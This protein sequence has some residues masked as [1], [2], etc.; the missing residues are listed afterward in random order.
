[1]KL[2]NL[3][4]IHLIGDYTIN[5]SNKTMKFTKISEQHVRD[6]INRRKASKG[7]GNDNILSYFLKLALPYVI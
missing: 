2:I 7:F 6:G 1:M 5:E 4:T 3:R